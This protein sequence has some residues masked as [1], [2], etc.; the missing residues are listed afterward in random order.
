VSTDFGVGLLPP[1]EPPTGL[2]PPSRAPIASAC[3]PYR[4]LIE[5]ALG[6]GRN[7][8]GIRQDLVDQHGFPARYASVRCRSQRGDASTRR[9]HALRILTR[10]KGCLACSCEKP[11]A[12]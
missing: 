12:L 6:R 1:A 4:K 11:V 9:V 5:L 2:P 10:V 7:A 3:E 8:M